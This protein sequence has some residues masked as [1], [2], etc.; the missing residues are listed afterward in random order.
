[1][2]PTLK[3]SS[4]AICRYVPHLLAFN[5]LPNQLPSAGIFILQSDG[6]RTFGGVRCRPPRNSHDPIDACHRLKARC[7]K[8][9]S[10]ARNR[11]SCLPT[12]SLTYTFLA[13]PLIWCHKRR[14]PSAAAASCVTYISIYNQVLLEERR[15]WGKGRLVTSQLPLTQ[16]DGRPLVVVDD[17][18]R[19]PRW[20]R[21][22]QD[23]FSH[24]SAYN[25]PGR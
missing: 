8:Y 17:V 7:V 16:M 20:W 22:G 5:F 1:M 24:S 23:T 4:P 15:N 10:L 3:R 12:H 6:R 13:L 19:I 25:K 18:P 2:L 11:G 9:Q 14:S 21:F